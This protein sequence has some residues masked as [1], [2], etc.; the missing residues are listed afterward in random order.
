MAIMKKILKQ[1]NPQKK[2]VLKNILKQ[3]NPQTYFPYT[4][5]LGNNDFALSTSLTKMVYFYG[6]HG[7]NSSNNKFW[8]VCGE[9]GIFLHC[10]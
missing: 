6:Y 10:Q 3:K 5:S 1:K 8:R 2:K 7:E 9:K 4:T